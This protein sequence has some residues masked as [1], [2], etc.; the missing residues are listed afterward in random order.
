MAIHTHTQGRFNNHTVHSLYR[1]MVMATIVMGVM[2]MGNIVPRAE[3]KPTSLAF[4]DT[5]LPLHH[6]GSLMSPLYPQLPVYAAFCLR[7]QCRLLLQ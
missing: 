3:Y 5:A 4:W 2:K 1:I 6:I 7:D